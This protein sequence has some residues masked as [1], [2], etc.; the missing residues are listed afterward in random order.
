MSDDL[1]FS[2]GRISDSRAKKI[3]VN[4]SMRLERSEES[5]S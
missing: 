5:G 2:A 4:A 1:G 3:S